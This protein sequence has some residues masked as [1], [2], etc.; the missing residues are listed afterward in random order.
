VPPG[1]CWLQKYQP[2]PAARTSKTKQ[3]ATIAWRRRG[4]GVFAAEVE[5][6][7][8]A[9]GV[10]KESDMVTGWVEL[11]SECCLQ[12]WQRWTPQNTALDQ[13]RSQRA[14]H[15]GEKKTDTQ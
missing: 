15:G 4:A 10:G 12:A 5:I 13:D 8:S 11:N 2:P 6:G 9:D 7:E 3:A 14:V 1:A